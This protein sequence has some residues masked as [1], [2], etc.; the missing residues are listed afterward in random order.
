[1]R[2]LLLVALS[3][4]VCLANAQS[5]PAKPVKL[6]VSYPTGGSSDLMARVFGAKLAEMWG[7][8]VVVENKP[9][10]AGS[11]GT[12]YAAKQ[13]PDGYSFMIANLGPIA[14]NPLLSNVPYNVEKDFAPVSLISTGPNVLVVRSD[15]EFRSLGEI[16]AHARAN[17]GKLNYGTSG[18]GSVS[19]LSSEMLKNIAR[20]QAVEVPYKGGVLAV[21]DLLGN[22][23]HFIFSDTLPAMQ[24]IRAGKLRALCITGAEAFALLPELAPCQAAAPGLVAVNWWGV[25]MPAGTPRSI[26]ARFHGDTVKTLADPDVKKK[27]AD[28]GVEAVSS[29]PEQF[30]AFIRAEMDKYGKLIKEANI[31]VN[32]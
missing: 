14:V 27:F 26:V 19:H 17:P 25:L 32:P 15:A 28:L 29:T 1:M 4:S 22:Q 5:Y 16:I 11:I 21:Q 2:G 13:P 31:K 8:Q 23:I 6:I 18:P 30:A 20:V 9:G 24:H 10:A 3:L 12:D 7:Q